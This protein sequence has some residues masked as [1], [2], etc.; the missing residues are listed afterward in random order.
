MFRSRTQSSRCARSSLLRPHPPTCL[1]CLLRAS[2]GV[3]TLTTQNLKWAGEP[4]LEFPLQHINWQDVKRC[5]AAAAVAVAVLAFC[6]VP[7]QNAASEASVAGGRALHWCALVGVHPR[8]R[9]AAPHSPFR[10][11]LAGLCCTA[12]VAVVSGSEWCAVQQSNPARHCCLG[13]TLQRTRPT[14]S[15]HRSLDR[16]RRPRSTSRSPSQIPPRPMRRRQ[17]ASLSSR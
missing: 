4:A 15:K 9:L 10:C 5:A 11:P 12:A 7:P 2:P 17:L 13:E 1:C 3:L 16:C 14:Q 8:S 6:S